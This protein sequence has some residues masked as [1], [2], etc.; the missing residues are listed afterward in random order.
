MLIKIKNEERHENQRRIPLTWNKLNIY[1]IKLN[2]LELGKKKEKKI[3][4]I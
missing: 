3:V 2:N 1:S 4:K